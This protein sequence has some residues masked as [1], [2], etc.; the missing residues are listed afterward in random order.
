M[1]D[2]RFHIVSDPLGSYNPY[3]CLKESPVNI[4][5]DR[6]E[7]KLIETIHKSA[8]MLPEE[9][10]MALQK[11]Y[12]NEA[13]GSIGKINLHTNLHNLN[14][15]K[16]NQIPMCADTGYPVFF[17]RMGDVEGPNLARLHT[18][19]HNAVRVCTKSGFIRPTVV[20]PLSRLNPGDNTGPGSPVL[21]YKADPEIDFCE[22]IYAPKGGGTEIF[23]PSFRTL[24]VADGIKGVKKFVFDGLL[25]H[26]NKTGATCPPNIV[27]VGIGGTA[28]S[29]MAIAKQA[30]CLRKV[31][32][33]NPDPRI[34][35]LEEEL[36]EVINSTG[37][38]PLGMGGETTIIDIH[39]EIALT[40]LVGTPIG[41]VCQCPAA[42]VG[43]LRISKDAEIS[44][45]SW[46]GWFK[47]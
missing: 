20:D 15:S 34:S 39:M 45:A 32:S 22:I 1:T 28:D 47:Y 36:L 41:M 7:K 26:G 4:D 9:N 40:H 2:K 44:K 30:A 29:C 18:A 12:Q 14:L 3:P 13:D 11:A 27:G 16:E 25:V 43:V 10:E 37:V 42:R 19:I 46:P 5:F 24:L 31:G 8:C 6:L 23:G 21:E 38:G 17:I 33:R 35:D